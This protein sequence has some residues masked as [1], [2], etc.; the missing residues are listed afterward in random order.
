MNIQIIWKI[1]LNDNYKKIIA[2][3]N[4][5]E[6]LASVK[7]LIYNILSLKKSESH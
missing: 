4:M 7:I 6:K 1:A 5:F 3:E 2:F